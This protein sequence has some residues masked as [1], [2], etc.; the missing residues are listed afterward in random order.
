MPRAES[1]LETVSLPALRLTL[2]LSVLVPARVRL[3]LLYFHSVPAPEMTPSRA[4]SAV[5]L[6]FRVKA[7]ASGVLARAAAFERMATAPVLPVLP[8]VSAPV[9]LKALP[10]MR[11]VAPVAAARV[12]GPARTIGRVLP[13]VKVVLASRV[14]PLKVRPPVAA[15]RL[16]SAPTERTPPLR[17]VPPE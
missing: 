5:W 11:S 14:P 15:P 1:V 13:R 4:T 17:K 2:P 10:S 3:L 8:M 7:T 9:P 12:A 16:A 6:T